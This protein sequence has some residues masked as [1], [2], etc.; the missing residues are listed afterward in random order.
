MTVVQEIS[1][2]DDAVFPGEWYEIIAEGHFWL[3]WRFR[4]FQQQLRDLALSRDA[5]WHGLDVGCGHG[6]VRRQIETS[7]R[8]TT[9]G[10][11]LNR[12]ALAQNRVA[13]GDT[14]RYDLQD[15]NP[16]FEGRYDFIVLFDVLEHIVDTPPFVD[17][18]A[19]HLKRGGWL[20]VN[21]P[22]IDA[23]R[24]EYDRVVGHV[25]RYSRSGLRHELEQR[26]FAVRDLRYWGFSMLPYLAYRWLRLRRRA[27]VAEVIVQGAQPPVPWMDTWIRRIMRMETSLVRH[28]PIGTSLLAA[29]VRA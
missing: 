21:V 17:A 1:R 20:F 10:A 29:A 6:V 19:Y 13:R 11:D 25:R 2:V 18:V 7:S 24:S 23:L 27:E 26:G 8:W 3:D 14:L 9:D 4:A 5:A 22:A 12:D 16:R 28:P 15:R